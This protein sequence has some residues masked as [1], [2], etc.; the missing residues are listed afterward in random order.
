MLTLCIDRISVLVII[1]FLNICTYKILLNVDRNSLAWVVPE[2]HNTLSMNRMSP[3]GVGDNQHV[4]IHGASVDVFWDIS[5][6]IL[7]FIMH[8]YY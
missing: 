8:F 5:I 2:K 1:L 4:L 3:M 7:L 6:C